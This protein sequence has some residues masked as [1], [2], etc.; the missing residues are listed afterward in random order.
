MARHKEHDISYVSPIDREP[1]Q[2]KDYCVVAKCGRADSDKKLFLFAGLHSMG[3]WGGSLYLTQP[4]HLQELYTQ[5][6]EENFAILVKCEFDSSLRVTSAE[7]IAGP[8]KL[9]TETPR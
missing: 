9:A 8:E 2:N 1:P 3:T 4:A 7:R 5:V 6:G